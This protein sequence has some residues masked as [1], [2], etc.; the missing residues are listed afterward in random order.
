MDQFLVNSE[1]WVGGYAFP[2]NHILASVLPIIVYLVIMLL[3]FAHRFLTA[4][5][6]SEPI[7]ERL[8]I[9][10]Y[11]QVRVRSDRD[12]VTEILL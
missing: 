3:K 9:L 8:H 5:V 7:T 1:T 2:S 10:R 6:S 4:V 11:T 12:S